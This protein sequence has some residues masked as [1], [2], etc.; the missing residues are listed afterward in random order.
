MNGTRTLTAAALLAMILVPAWVAS[1]AQG[2]VVATIGGHSFTQQEV[3]AKLKTQLAQMDSEL[4]ELRRRTIESM[5]NEYLIAQAAKKANLSVD[6]YLKREIADKTPAPTE[7]D[8]KKFYDQHK[9]QINQPYDK[10]KPMLVGY[11][12]NQETGKRRDDLLT[13]LRAGQPLKIM[14]KAPRFEVASGG[15]PTLGPKDAQVTIVEFGDFQCPFCKRSEDALNQ[16]RAKYGDK[17]R[18]V[19]MDFP[20]QMHSNALNAAEGGRC[21]GEQGKFW[22][23]HDALFA[24]QS[25]IAP[26]DLKASAAKLGLDK[27]KFD[28]CLDQGKYERDI[29]ADMAEGEKLGVNGTPAFFINGRPLSG[30]RPAG[31]FEEIIDEEL[32]SS[33]G[34]MADAHR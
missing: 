33:G 22:P 13:Q 12:Q 19:Y 11:M 25:K 3:D 20:L 2:H 24:D 31:D 10:V 29:R 30:A 21:A 26:A 15:H 5:A 16:V 34:K 17:V 9:T 18:L 8:M 1:A 28:A 4:Y 27:A 32:A 6:D 14:L 23:F 7:A